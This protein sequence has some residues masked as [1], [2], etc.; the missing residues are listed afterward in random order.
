MPLPPKNAIESLNPISNYRKTKKTIKLFWREVM[1]NNRGGEKNYNRGGEKN[2]RDGRKQERRFSGKPP[3]SRGK[4]CHMC[5]LAGSSPSHYNSHE[6]GECG[7]LTRTDVDSIARLNGLNEDDD[8][9]E[10]VSDEE[11]SE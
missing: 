7:L 10:E 4:E 1:D 9:R 11:E 3:S 6:I 5:K 8:R 2:L